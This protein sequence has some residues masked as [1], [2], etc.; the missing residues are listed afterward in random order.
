MLDDGLWNGFS[1]QDIYL[2]EKQEN[3]ISYIWDEII[4][5][6]NWRTMNERIR[7][8]FFQNPIMLKYMLIG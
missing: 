3:K 7:L 2:A 5:E 1:N 8:Y 6:V 4:E